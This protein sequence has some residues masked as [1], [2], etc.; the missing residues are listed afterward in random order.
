MPDDPTT[1]ANTNSPLSEWL[2]LSQAARRLGWPREKLRSLARRSRLEVRRTNTGELLVKLTPEL[3]AQAGS[4]GS[5]P[6][7]ADGSAQ[8]L[9][10]VAGE[11]SPWAE[12]ALARLAALE[13]AQ[14]DAE[15]QV[16]LLKVE[17][18]QA[19]AERE[20]ARAV[21]MADVA[22][23]QAEAAFKDELI[24]ELKAMLADARRPWWRRWLQ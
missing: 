10:A 9:T 13:V 12:H 5:A 11:G 3:L 16:V 7:L 17:L 18:A 21:A 19:R 8:R 6:G 14:A 22:A 15:A 2:N 4:P 24:V 23:A 20:A 1:V